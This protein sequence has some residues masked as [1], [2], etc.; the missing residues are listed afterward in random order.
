MGK[1][2]F[3]AGLDNR[4]GDLTAAQQADL[5]K[6][7]LHSGVD[8]EFFRYNTS[9]D[10]VINAIKKSPDA[11]VILF[12]AGCTKAN[13]VAKY[14]K[15]AK[16]P[17]DSL[18]I[19]EPYTVSSG[20]F[21]IVS[22]AIKQ[23]VPSKNVYSG[24]T[25]ATGS[26]IKGATKLSGR[27]GH[28][29]SLTPLGKLLSGKIQQK[30]PS[31]TTS[32]TSGTSGT[33]G[34]SGIKPGNETDP[35]N[36]SGTSGTSGIDQNAPIPVPGP[37]GVS[38]KFALKVKSGPGVIIGVT[39]VD[40]TEGIANFSGIQFDAPG[41]YVLSVTS[42]SPDIDSAATEIKIKVNPPPEAIPQDPKGASASE[43]S[44][45]RP[46]IA[47]IDQPTIDLGPIAYDRQGSKNTDATAVASTVGKTVFVDY[48]GTQINDRDIQSMKLY[49]DGIVPKIDITFRDTN[50]MLAK[51]PP[52]D[53][54]RFD[55]FINSKS[56]NLKDIHLKFK[57][58][59]Y[60]KIENGLYQFKGT[61]D[62]TPLYRM[63]FKV[64]RGTSFEVLRQICKEMGLGFNSNIDN[65][66]DEMPWRNIG[67]KQFKFME[68]IVKH[69]YISD[70]SFMAGYIDYY[71]CFNYVDVEKEMVRD[72]RNDVG[73]E[74]GGFDDPEPDNDKISKLMLTTE[75]GS[76]QSCML[77][78]KTGERNESTKTSIEQGYKTRTKFYDKVKKMFL[79]FDVDSTTSDGSKSHILKGAAGDKE[80]FDNNYVTKYEGK[81][82]TDNSHKNYNYA[83]TQNRIN[84]DNMVKV[85]MDIK[86]PNP[87]LNLY[88]YMK[89]NATVIKEGATPTQPERVQWRW[90]GEWM[91]S[92]INYSFLNGKLDQNATLVRKEMGKDPAE[93]AENGTE[94]KKETKDEKNENPIAGSQS[95]AVAKPNEAFKP[96][97]E[98]TVQDQSGNRYI[99]KINSLV[100]NGDE[101]KAEIRDID[102]VS[103]AVVTNPDSVAGASQ[104]GA[105]QSGTQSGT[106]STP[107]PAEGSY[108]PEI[109]FRPRSSSLG[110]YEEYTQELVT[111]YTDNH[112]QW[113]LSEN[114]YMLPY[115]NMRK[116]NE[117]WIAIKRPIPD[118]KPEKEEKNWT[119]KSW[120][121][122]ELNDTGIDSFGDAVLGPNYDNPKWEIVKSRITSEYEAYYDT[123][124]RK[125]KGYIKVLDSTGKA[126]YDSEVDGIDAKTPGPELAL[127]IDA[128]A[129]GLTPSY[130]L[131]NSW[132][133]RNGTG[134]PV[135]LDPNPIPKDQLYT[136]VGGLNT[137]FIDM[138]NPAKYTPGTY[139]LE[140]KY[141]V[142]KLPKDGGKRLLEPK[143][144][145]GYSP[146][147]EKILKETFTI[148]RRSQRR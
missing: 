40:I 57:I 69:S 8:V 46:I 41:D 92:D 90:S 44:G 47:Q 9:D 50:G 72:I 74:T 85:Q 99:I 33:N 148:S 56:N 84:L 68:D 98:Y 60:N 11:E 144:A 103:S 117:I 80:A 10:T 132:F 97:E 108:W 58:E 13:A 77:F 136:P 143:D 122:Y 45:T 65:T 86:L 134:I 110:Q 126:V 93:M 49:H 109:Y 104:S 38:G 141:N 30:P 2:I 146:Y 5:I 6:K 24:G 116:N 105:S 83:V 55:I 89:V 125:P 140:V 123:A 91:I 133:T 42:T 137:I 59:D 18:H 31:A 19:N 51:E 27:S 101:V 1:V 3:V 34:T 78:V 88:K 94:A 82:D 23:G 15:E 145:N 112:I 16:R 17:L 25:E 95:N 106:A 52:R 96:G 39:E 54:T 138:S 75:K 63:K 7:G 22:G 61:I 119:P 35:N 115:E 71:Y 100:E 139:T 120:L 48:N 66:K 20:T 14:L 107:P 87:N 36:T 118:F 81:I 67:D 76:Q 121:L 73:I 111:S 62:V 142:P 4:K 113:I 12:S 114:R 26:N 28:F 29:Q 79:V 147:V 21:N 127:G 37:K 131:N 129:A 124:W 130:A 32:G 64:Y 43:V 135:Q 70:E 128:A 102:Y 53:D